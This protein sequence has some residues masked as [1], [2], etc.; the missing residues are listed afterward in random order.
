MD[1]T[2]ITKELVMEVPHT[3]HAWDEYLVFTGADLSNFFEF[4]AEVDV[5]LGDNPEKKELF[6]LTRPTIIRVPPSCTTVRST[7]GGFRNPSFFGG[8][9]GRRLV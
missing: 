2:S 5:W 3:H 1:F 9:F 4:D 6:T 8:I 7:L